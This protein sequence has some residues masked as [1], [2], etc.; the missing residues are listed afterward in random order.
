MERGMNAWKG[1]VAE[2]PPESGM[3]YFS[4]ATRPEELMALA[5][6][7]EGGSHHFYSEVTEMLEDPEAK[8]LFKDLSTAEE[9]HQASLFNLYKEFSGKTSDQRF[10]GSVMSPEGQGDVME[11][12]IR[13]SD[14]LKWAKGKKLI[15]IFEFSIS[16]ETNA[17]DLYIKMERQ[18]KDPRSAQVFKML[19]RE[20]KQHLEKLS[21]LLERIA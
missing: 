8:D 17:Y 1:L 21:T 14:A 3:P 6:Y 15:D 20:E 18:M 16:S 2:G 19:S 11:G 10:P 13:V 4:A 9:R 7:L 12:G 5:W